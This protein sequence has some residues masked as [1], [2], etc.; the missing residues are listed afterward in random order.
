MKQI[1]GTAQSSSHV[2]VID[3]LNFSEFI[4][5]SDETG[6]VGLKSIDPKYPFFAINFCIGRRT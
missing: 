2:A 3:T 5:F 1:I 4:V 6:D